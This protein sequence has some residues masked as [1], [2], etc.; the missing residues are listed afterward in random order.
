MVNLGI[1]HW[2]F[3]A[4][5]PTQNKHE[6][7]LPITKIHQTQPDSFRISTCIADHDLI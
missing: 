6:P 2:D 7:L 5:N 3:I 4:K 1:S